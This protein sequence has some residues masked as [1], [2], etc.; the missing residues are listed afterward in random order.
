MC[1]YNT[2]GGRGRGVSAMHRGS[3]VESK[4]VLVGEAEKEAGDAG[5]VKVAMDDVIR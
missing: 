2:C 4:E 5:E 1:L 3:K